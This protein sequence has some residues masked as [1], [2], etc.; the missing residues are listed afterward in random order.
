[1]PE[2]FIVRTAQMLP[3]SKGHLRR[4][5]TALGVVGLSTALAALLVRHFELSE[6]IMVYLLGIMAVSAGFG[7]GPALLAAASS[8]AAFDFCFVPPYYTFRVADMRFIFTFAVMFIVGLVISGLS[9][10]V[11]RQTERA[12][13]AEKEALR[14]ALLNSIS[15]D[16]R[17]P[18]CAIG[19]S[20]SALLDE[21][22]PLPRAEQRKLL[23]TIQEEADH[24]NR[25]VRNLL[26]MTRLASGGLLIKK[27]WMPLEEVIGS[28]LGRLDRLLEQHPVRV[29]LPA[30]LPLVPLDGML[31]EQ[32]L[33]NLLENAA[34]YTPAG[35]SIQVLAHRNQDSV[36]VEV[37]DSGPGLLTGSED[38]IFEKFYRG[39]R[40]RQD[41][42]F[43]LGLAICRGLIEAHGGTIRA[44]NQPEGGAMFRFTLPI[45]G[46]PPAL[47][48]EAS[49]EAVS[50]PASRSAAGLASELRHG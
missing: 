6:V 5:G 14:T 13:R 33:Y 32:V 27:E 20:A 44:G 26:D 19:G 29:S 39:T 4:Y 8:V 28:A 11:K 3:P 12:L 48:A 42:G 36:T 41:G 43:G 10:E 37:M 38:Q 31:I 25:L 47:P 1:M 16:L 30:D 46:T 18:L 45:E 2:T 17:T 21:E 23:S 9:G 34:K 7:R 22:H 15:H 49:T 40:S 35:T 50:D 24:L